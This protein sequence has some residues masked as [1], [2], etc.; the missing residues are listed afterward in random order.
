MLDRRS[1]ELAWSL[2]DPLE[3]QR[4]GSSTAMARSPAAD[5]R[6]RRDRVE[7]PTTDA[8]RY[9]LGAYFAEL[10]APLRRRL[11]SRPQQHG[12]RRRA[13]RAAGLFLVARLRGEPIGCGALKLHGDDPAE[14]KRM[15]VA[16][17]RGGSASGGVCSRSWSARRVGRG[18]GVRLETNRALTEAIALYRSAGYPEVAAVQR[19]AVRPPLV[20]EITRALDGRRDVRGDACVVWRSVRAPVAFRRRGPVCRLGRAT[21][22]AEQV[23]DRV[24][25]EA[26]AVVHA[27]S[28]G[29]RPLRVVEGDLLP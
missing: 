27:E 12:G 25:C 19:R 18:D 17:P 10:D 7:D 21:V 14:I 20:R 6:P 13:D 28:V 1:D 23:G 5:R 15:W 22:A 24:L 16:P 3:R 4:R 8:A 29:R 2:L 9:C 26:Q 11:R